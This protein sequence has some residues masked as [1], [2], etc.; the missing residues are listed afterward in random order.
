MRP[1]GARLKSCLA[2]ALTPPPSP[3][4]AARRSE[5]CRLGFLHARGGFYLDA[6]LQPRHPGSRYTPL[7]QTP[8][9]SLRPTNV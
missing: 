5:L 4:T 8:L 3:L 7:P 9:S 2:N 6:D 1:P